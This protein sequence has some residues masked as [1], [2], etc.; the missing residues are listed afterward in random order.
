[1]LNLLFAQGNLGQSGAN[2]L[3]IGVDPKGTAFGG[4]GI[5][6]AQG[7]T[8]LYWNPA[9]AIETENIDVD[10]SYTN[11]F[12]DT[13]LAYGGIVKNLGGFGAVGLS[14]T[15]FY[16]NEMEVTTVYQS[17]GTGE[18][19]NAGDIAAGLSYARSLTDRFTFGLTVKYVREYIWN[20]S[21]HQIAFDIGS[22]YRTDFYNLRLGMAVRNFAGKMKFSGDNID[23]RLL[24]EESRSQENNPREERLTPDFRLPQVFQLGIA[25]DPVK[26]E[27][28]N[29]TL[30]ADVDVPADNQERMIFA[31]E[32]GFHKIAYIRGGYRVNYDTGDLSLG[33][34]LNFVVS[35]VKSSLDYSFSTHGLLGDVHRFGFGIS[36]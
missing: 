16:M 8:A 19:Y 12:L 36:L 25:F 29:I 27:S 9:G 21:A 35:G 18:Y 24:E 14:I 34:G 11:W 4:A 20:E 3:Q 1:M 22:L 17:E 33:G 10:F 31:A 30:I 28:W 15:S 32:Y 26:T 6:L 23:N 5:A 7:A 2:F 13:K